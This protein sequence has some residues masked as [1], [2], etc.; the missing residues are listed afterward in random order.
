LTALAV[1]GSVCVR[2][3]VDPDLWGHLRFGL[4]VAADRRLTSVD[5]YSFTQDKPWINHEWLSELLFALVHR[6]AGVSGLLLLK[7]AILAAAFLLLASM[8]RGVNEDKRWWLLAISIFGIGPIAATFRPHLWT[9]LALA[10]ILKILSS[11]RGFWWLPLVF[12]VWANM[13]GGWIVGIAVLGL[14]IVGRAF[15]TRDLRAQLPFVLVLAV[16]VMATLINPYGWG[17]WRFLLTTVRM[18]RDISEWRPLWEHFEIRYVLLWPL[19]VG[20]VAT[21]ALARWRHLT[22]AASLPVLWLGVNGLFVSRLAPLFSEIALLA[23]AQAWRSSNVLAASPALPARMPV[24]AKMMV[25]AAVLA[26]VTLTPFAGHIRCLE[27]E[28]PSAPDLVAAGAFESPD[29][30]GRLVVPF[31]WG[32]YGIW[33]W[34]PRL[35]VSMD[36]RRETIYSDGM[37]DLHGEVVAGGARGRDY[38]ARVRPEYVWLPHEGGRATGEWL[39]EQGYRLDVNTPRSFIATRGDLPPLAPGTPMPA[40][41]R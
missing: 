28:G 11:G 36:G 2:A 18:G 40:C 1:A 4:D 27:I 8:T 37:L 24:R 23:T 21:T 15:D 7:I 39:T 10:V 38:L 22:W 33:H 5:P 30:R 32:E 25:D 41:F 17:L 29:A 6:V 35:R 9:I 26:A 12:A 16:A 19:T 3:A 20:V 31:N 14:W 13:H 34:G